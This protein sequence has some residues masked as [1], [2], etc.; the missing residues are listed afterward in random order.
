[1]L[2]WHLDRLDP[3][4]RAKVE[5]GLAGDPALQ[6]KSNRLR[7]ILRPLDHWSIASPPHHLAEKV[8]SFVRHATDSVPAAAPLPGRQASARARGWMPFR[9]PWE[10]VAAAACITLIVSAFVPGVSAM[11]EKS[12]RALCANN[13]DSIFRGVSAYQAS[14]GGSL[15]FAGNLQGASWLPECGDKPYASNSRHVFLLLKH[16]Y[17]TNPKSFLC[18]SD[19]SGRAMS[20]AQRAGCAD[21]S[22]V[23]NNSYSTLNLAGTSPHLRPAKPIAF[24]SDPNPLFVNAR[25]NPGI[26]PTRANSLAHGGKGQTV[27]VLDGS[28]RWMTKPTYGP[29][30]DNL[31]VIENVRRYTGVETSVD[32]DDIQL[33]P[34]YPDTDPLVRQALMR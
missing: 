34:G 13:L 16:N 2:D 24:I 15:P 17:V 5:R 31:W 30:Q 32:D 20:S 3:E 6:S 25:F 26:D 33:V 7:R 19:R 14:F 21:F 29:K 18:P 9:S 12:R 23:S 28:A 8:L 1:M 10:L 4:E 27:L 22:E 11:R